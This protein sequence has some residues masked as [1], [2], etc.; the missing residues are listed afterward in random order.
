MRK[1]LQLAM[2]A[3]FTAAVCHAQEETTRD[4]LRQVKEDNASF[5]F[6]ESQMGE[7]DDMT[8]NII[9]V[10]SN[11][12]VYSSNVGYLFSPMRFKFR[13]YNSKYNEIY[14]NGVNVNNAE[15]GQFNYSTIGGM[16]NAT[17][18]VD[19][20]LP[21][22]DNQFGM[23]GI[24]GSNNYDF[25]A[26]DYAAGSRLTLSGCNRNYIVRGMLTHATGITSKGWAFMG[27]VGYRWGREGF[28]EGTFYNSLSYFLSAQKIFNDKH[29]LSLTTWGNPSERSQQGASTDEAY[30]LANDRYYNPYWG[31]QNGKKRNSRVVNNYE[32]SALLT[33]DYQINDKAKLTTSLIG[34]YVMYSSTKLNYNNTTNPAPDYWKNFPS[35]Y[36]N[37]WDE[38]DLD[39]RDEADLAAWTNS[40]NYWTSS[41]A[42]RQ[43]QWD[44]LY[45]ANKQLNQT[46]EDAAYYIQAKHNDHLMINL[47]STLNFDFDKETKLKAGL[48]IGTNKGMHYQTMED[49]LGANV[50]H[51]INNYAVGTYPASDPRVQYD[52]NNPNGEVH[53]GDRFGYDYNLYVDN[54][55]LWAQYTKDYGRTH[56]YLMGKIGG[57][58]MWRKG[59][60]RNGLAPE[61][62]YGKGKKAYFLDGGVKIGSSINLGYGN[63]ISLGVGYEARAPQAT[64]AFVAPEINNDFVNN[65]KCERI[66]SA[67]LN[68]SLNAS[69]VRASLSGYFTHVTQQNEWQN[70]YFDDENSFTYVSLNGV[71]KNY[72]GVELGLQFKVTSNFSIN[73][74]GSMSEAKYAKNTNVRYMLSNEGTSKEDICRNEGMRE[75]GTPL[76]VGNI[77]LNYR[78]NG[79][80]FNLN[81]NYYDRIY[82]GYSP[83]LRYEETLKTMGNIDNE[84]NYIV[85][86]QAKG[87]G[88]FMLDASIGKSFRVGKNNLNVNLM[89]TNILNNTK[90]VSGGYEQS[91]S[92]Y[93]VD[94]N[95]EQASVRT[96][97]FQK[98]PKKYYA[99][100]FNGMLNINYR[101]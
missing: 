67:E 101:F 9:M 87:K 53:E 25:R 36:F 16:N 79:W 2:A 94:S 47:G 97:K 72:Y 33:W 84:G 77:G 76:T 74:I 21:F 35:Y 26:S 7:D 56:S 12:N 8:Q 81:G 30:W 17:R 24:G 13:G 27:T 95:G 86:E 52:L 60:M 37:V 29:S 93:T 32:P 44:K 20:A 4:P 82:L 70:F 10:N 90:M 80:Y 68:Y 66:G 75:S 73:L 11:N 57:T 89:L 14:F 1:E 98:N 91:R 34:R 92:S 83:C 99:Q 3:L 49:L 62:S 65:L 31:Y 50:F 43:I 78:V 69:W 71:E 61:N 19:Y 28:A 6:T 64:T 59:N 54:V 41:K 45:F 55:K 51:N 39:N 46:G 40:Y 58:Q 100:G 85:P 18:N 15:N 22:E 42:N 63:I 88:G 5:V 38:N 48:Q 96:Y 23:P